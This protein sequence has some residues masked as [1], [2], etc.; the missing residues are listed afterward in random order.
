M[1][2]LIKHNPKFTAD[3][4][5][6]DG[7]VWRPFVGKNFG[8]NGR[9]V[10]VMGH[11]FPLPLERYESE[12]ERFE[13]ADYYEVATDEFAFAKKRWVKAFKGY[14]KAAAGR[15]TDYGRD[16]LPE[17]V[18]KIVETVDG[19]AFNNFIQG[20]VGSAKKNPIA[21]AD[22]IAASQRVWSEVL[23]ILSV[24]HCVAWGGYVFDYLRKMDGVKT[25]AEERIPLKGFGYALLELPNSQRIHVLKIH[26]PAF[27][28]F[29]RYD[30]TTQKVLSDFLSRP[31]A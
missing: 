30:S 9:R 1:T 25:I 17:S 5:G 29:K 22:H 13:Q 20:I 3:L 4:S 8:A 16:S 24:T 2:T 6:I 18:S 23:P 27:P 19:I 28:G 21:E 26:H 7:L 15:Q 12:R 10:L 11:N 14:L 31:A